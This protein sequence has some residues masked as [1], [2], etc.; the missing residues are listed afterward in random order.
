MILLSSALRLTVV[1]FFLPR[2]RE[3]R[4]VP[5]AGWREIVAHA[6]RTTETRVYVAPDSQDKS[7]TPVVK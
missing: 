6:M 7:G 3:V 1:L 2:V 5:D 4:P